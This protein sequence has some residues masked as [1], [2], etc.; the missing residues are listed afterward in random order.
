MVKNYNLYCFF[1]K[2]YKLNLYKKFSL[3][4]FNILIILIANL[5]IF[6]ECLNATEENAPNDYYSILQPGIHPSAPLGYPDYKPQNNIPSDY[7]NKTSTSTSNINKNDNYYKA[8]KEEAF[9][10]LLNIKIPL[11]PEQII[12]LNQ[13]IDKSQ[14]ASRTSPNKPPQPVSSTI[15]IDLSPGSSPPLVRLAAGF[16]SS[17]VFVDSTGQPW[18]IADYSL[19][20]PQ[21][22]NI[23]WDK[24]TN[25]LFI[26]STAP[27]VTANLAVRLA[28]LDTPIMISLVTGQRKVD[29]R[30]DFQIRAHGPN[31]LPPVGEAIYPNFTISPALLK[32]LDG[33]PPEN[34]KE[35]QVSGNL[36]KAWVHNG[37][38]IFRTNL[39][40][41]SPAWNAT[42]SSA[43]GTKVYEFAPTPLILASK[44]GKTVKIEISGF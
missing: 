35:L 25:A 17:L 9:Q 38:M 4:F 36:G 40:L 27:Y 20:N 34:S 14:R 13:E 26:Q 10:R 16:V 29:Y 32:T 39:V 5:L 2:I 11:D 19:G 15:D 24:K 21:E 22:V 28:K 41:I 37:K 33:I 43:D 30:V 23:Q 3:L 1:D 18:P 7:A 8:L 44:D 31:A 6:K 42:I 12:Q